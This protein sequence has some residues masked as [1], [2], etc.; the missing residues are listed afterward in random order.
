M[1]IRFL[2]S[3]RTDGPPTRQ[4]I[5]CSV[6][7]RYG[8]IELV[9][10]DIRTRQPV[11]RRANCED[12]H[13]NQGIQFSGEVPHRKRCTRHHHRLC[14]SGLETKRGWKER[15]CNVFVKVDVGQSHIITP[16]I[17]VSDYSGEH[18]IDAPYP[19]KHECHTLHVPLKELETLCDPRFVPGSAEFIAHAKALPPP[20]RRVCFIRSTRTLGNIVL[21]EL[22]DEPSLSI[23]RYPNSIMFKP[24]NGGPIATL[25][26]ENFGDFAQSVSRSSQPSCFSVS[27]MFLRILLASSYTSYTPVATTTSNSCGA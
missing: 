9:N 15:V 6:R 16:R 10:C 4:P 7:L 8:R 22:S 19:L 25:T 3:R 20:F 5:S 14:T 21:D 23:I 2:P 11:Q 27:L 17:D 26:I 12:A 18:A 1:A 13:E 24:L